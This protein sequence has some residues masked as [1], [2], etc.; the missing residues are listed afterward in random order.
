[1]IPPIYWCVNKK[2]GIRLLIITTIAAYISIVIKNLTRLSRPTDKLIG[3]TY[4]TYSFPSGHAFGTTTF[5]LYTIAVFRKNWM[6][7]LGTLIV[8]F[9]S[10]S[11]VYL[12]VHYLS[13][14]I[15]G[16]AFGVATVVGFIV[17]EP[18]IDRFV[19]NLSFRMRIFY[20]SIPPILLIVHSSLVFE[21]DIQNIK[22]SSGLL[23]IFIGSILEQEYIQFSE[24]TTMT[25]KVLRTILGL[26][27][28]YLAYFGLGMVLPHSM[29]SCIFVSFLG[30]FSVTFIVP[31]I[32]TN[33]E[34]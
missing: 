5:W 18:F 4:S 29:I 30:G 24:H 26:F 14:I 7:I 9:V 27:I 31:F 23:G 19:K 34:E 32:F 25:N 8:V 17:F 12:K 22:L 28:A 13:D 21:L 15:A 2:F 11:R 6:L 20:A 33:I 16:I 1:V 3:T 10:I